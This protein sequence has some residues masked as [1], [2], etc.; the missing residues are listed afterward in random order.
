MKT[1]SINLNNVD[2]IFPIYNASNLSLKNL[3]INKIIGKKIN[4][5]NDG[6][7]LV[8]ALENI[9][10]NISSGE[11]VGL[12]GH[13]GSGKTTLLRL[14]SGI[15]EPINGEVLINGVCNSL[16]DI[17]LGIDPEATG[18]ENIF[19]RSIMMGLKPSDIK[20]EIEDIIIFQ[21]RRFY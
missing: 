9:N 18:R 11:R 6:I 19:L 5:N 3:A 21:V 20:Q 15:F 8:K 1:A 17:N 4:Y 16:I 7:S 14:L 2:V 13:N 10:L 12:V